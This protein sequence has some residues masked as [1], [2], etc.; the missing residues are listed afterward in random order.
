[1]TKWKRALFCVMAAAC[2]LLTACADNS[3]PQ[4]GTQSQTA[5]REVSLSDVH[6]AVK[7]VYGEA[8]IP[9]MEQDAESISALY[10][11]TEDMYEEAVAEISMI[12]VHVDTFLAFKAKEGQADAVEEKLIAY[13]DYLLGD[14]MQ[15]PMNIP[16]IEAS[17]VV[18][19]GNYVFF[20]QLGQ[21]E[22]EL[23]DEDGLLKQFQES[24]QLAVDAIK[25]QFQ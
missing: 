12:S 14:A 25:A 10:G 18:R 13:R 5:G 15:Y 8:Y 6:Q 19:E 2:V 22:D 7:D 11:I 4:S 17:Q 21:A 1:M 16:K 23:A 9:S 3:Q 20:V 24:N